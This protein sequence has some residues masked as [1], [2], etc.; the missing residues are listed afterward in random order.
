MSAKH[1]IVLLS[2]AVK[3]DEDYAWAVFCNIAMPIKDSYAPAFGAASVMG[4]MT[5]AM[6]HKV[7][8]EAAAHLMQHLFHYDMT[9]HPLYEYGKGDAQLYAEF[10]IA[11]DE[12]EDAAIAKATGA[13]A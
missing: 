10:R 7:A 13:A 4:W 3:A 5:D 9:A 11:M 8:N 12:Q 6:Q 1:P 2:D